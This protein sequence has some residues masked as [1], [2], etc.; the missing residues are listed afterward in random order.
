[1]ILISFHLELLKMELLFELPPEL[2]NYRLIQ[3]SGR[4]FP[5]LVLLYWFQTFCTATFFKGV[6]SSILPPSMVRNA[7]VVWFGSSLN[8]LPLSSAK[9]MDPCV[10][11]FGSAVLTSSSTTNAPPFDAGRILIFNITVPAFPVIFTAPATSRIASAKSDNVSP[12]RCDCSIWRNAPSMA[13]CAVAFVCFFAI[14]FISNTCR[15]VLEIV[16]RGLQ[17]QKFFGIAAGVRVMF[18]GERAIGVLNLFRRGVDGHAERRPPACAARLFRDGHV[19]AKGL[20]DVAHTVAFV[21]ADI[22]NFFGDRPDVIFDAVPTVTCERDWTSFEREINR[23]A[24]IFSLRLVRKRQAV[25]PQF[26]IR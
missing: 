25:N 5:D 21:L 10:S 22:V 9:K 18:L 20:L 3:Q 13:G 17:A 2:E 11:A 8:K 24:T 19:T 26:Y 23:R 4:A 6:V 12:R 15:L 14:N 7:R 16:E 1:M